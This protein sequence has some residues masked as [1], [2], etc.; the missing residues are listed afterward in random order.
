[1]ATVAIH[2][3]SAAAPRGLTA[4]EVEMRRDA[5]LV[6]VVATRSTRSYWTIVR[7]NALNV[8]NILLFTISAGL[9]ALGLYGDALVT[10][11]LVIVNVGIGIFQ[12][13]RAKRQLDSIALLNRPTAAVI[14]D[15]R[16][17]Q[18]DPSDLVLGDAVVLKAGDQIQVDGTIVSDGEV[19]VD[20]SNLTGESDLVRKRRGDAVHSGSV[21]MT[22]SVIY[23]ATDVGEDTIAHKMTEQARAY[24]NVRT[25]LQREVDLILRAMGVLVAL[26]ALQTLWSFDHIYDQF[27]LIESVKA[28][29][30]LVALI[31]QGLVLMIAVTYSL[32]VM[33]LAK[34]GVLI[35]RLNAVESTSHIDVLCVDKTGTLTTQALELEDLH[36]LGLTDEA[37]RQLVG[38]YAASVTDSNKT[39]DALKAAFPATRSQ[40]DDEVAFDS[41]RKWS[42]LGL[43][44]ADQGVLVLGAPEIL[45][46][47]V[48]EY[49]ALAERVSLWADRGLRV[50]LFACAP[51]VSKA[52][53]ADG[54]PELPRELRPLAV[55]AI[56]DQLREGARETIQAFAKIGV[57]LKVISGD[58]PE[59]VL[60]LARQ[61]GIPE[62]A[63]AVSGTQ[64]ADLDD[65]QMEEVA[66]A[67]TVFGR[68]TPEQKERL[69]A[70]LTRRGHY[71]AMTGDG[72]ND[73][74]ALKQ[75][76]V[77]IAMRSGSEATRGV[78]D[79]VLMDDSFSVL[80]ETFS[81]GQ[82]IMRGMYDAIKLFLTRTLFV[83]LLIL[84]ASLIEVEFPLTPKQNS[85]LATLTVGI[86]AFALAIWAVP[87]RTPRRLLPTIVEFVIPAA[88]VVAAISLSVYEF[89]L[90]MTGNTMWA[91][92]AVT[93][94]MVACGLLIVLFAQPPSPAWVGG[95]SLNGDLR[96][97][98]MV[99]GLFGVYVLVLFVT[100]LREFFE[101]TT[102][103]FSGYV[104]IGFVVAGWAVIVRTL[105][106]WTLGRR[107]IRMWR[108][109]YPRGFSIMPGSEPSGEVAEN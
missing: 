78:A 94:T 16:S 28:G 7:Q 40:I 82:R 101:I 72:V 51:G 17:E 95:S 67:N 69:V 104:M 43:S 92:A 61:C 62:S 10:A 27:P 57:Q 47:S 90:T 15:G 107:V 109:R 32:A 12:E 68:V 14:R 108:R 11:G 89:F 9:V 49:D 46:P 1:M 103:P 38:A 102:L 39:N 105:W 64:L 45:A 83:A 33:R 2:P 52:R 42:A 23:E 25:P 31:P 4:A 54:E 93:T 5:G 98:A 86:P 75:A 53:R 100:P 60:A 73:I 24:R 29:A 66:T 106:R 85:L 77:A 71:V 99:V 36:P 70:A 50:L 97:A 91:Q 56:R 65:A 19:G 13:V 3:G 76:K 8:V 80:P 63:T 37:C 59:T 48:I 22:G 88:V 81:E 20:E 6:N 41:A 84:G 26:L 55:I 44:G 87:G 96:P 79:I 21:C 74:L 30:V 58:N 34:T 18:V 35:Q